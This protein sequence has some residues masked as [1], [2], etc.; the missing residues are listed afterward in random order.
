MDNYFT[1]MDAYLY[2]CPFCEHIL[3]LVEWYK[4]YSDKNREITC[5]HCKKNF[6]ELQLSLVFKD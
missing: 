3:T 2:K 6:P 5:P 4:Y 1:S